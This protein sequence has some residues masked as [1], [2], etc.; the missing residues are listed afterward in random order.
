MALFGAKY[1]DR[2]ALREL[3]EIT[4]LFK[5]KTDQFP[6]QQYHYEA[7]TAQIKILNL[8]P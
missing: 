8:F 2:F 4:N 6:L 1:A 3:K 7:P 5:T